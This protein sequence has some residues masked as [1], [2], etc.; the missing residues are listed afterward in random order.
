MKL[1][2]SVAPRRRRNDHVSSTITKYP[3]EKANACRCRIV[4]GRR[5]SH[6]DDAFQHQ[7]NRVLR[8][9][10]HGRLSVRGMLLL[11]LQPVLRMPE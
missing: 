11:R 8:L 2:R 9:L 1:Q 6:R 4:P 3:Y 5:A 10:Q 7:G